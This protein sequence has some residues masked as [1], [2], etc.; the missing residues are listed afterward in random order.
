MC[1]WVF[2][3]QNLYK[4]WQSLKVFCNSSPQVFEHMGA[5][6]TILRFFSWWSCD[7]SWKCQLPLNSYFYLRRSR[8]VLELWELLLLLLLRGGKQFDDFWVS[9]SPTLNFLRGGIRGS[10]TRFLFG[11]GS[12]IRKSDLFGVVSIHCLQSIFLFNPSLKKVINIYQKIMYIL[13]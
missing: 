11:V 7:N 9:S 2:F 6:H 12:V 3:G 8:Q 1:Y 4:L 10:L 5:Q 13:L